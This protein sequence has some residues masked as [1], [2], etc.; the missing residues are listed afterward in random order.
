MSVNTQQVAHYKNKLQ[1]EIDAWDLYEA[2][3]QKEKVVIIDARSESSYKKEHIPGAINFPHRTMTKETTQGKL[4]FDTLY[5]TDPA[6]NALS[7]EKAK[8]LANQVENY[9][10]TL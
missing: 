3:K 10:L 1:Y 2:V 4:N 7:E 5:V 6:G 9:L 8:I